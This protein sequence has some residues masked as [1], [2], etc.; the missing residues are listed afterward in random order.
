MTD[1]QRQMLSEAISDYFS[2]VDSDAEDI[3]QYW[4]YTDAGNLDD[5]I[6]RVILPYTSP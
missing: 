5:L 6:D 3:L 4:D 1:A 2:S